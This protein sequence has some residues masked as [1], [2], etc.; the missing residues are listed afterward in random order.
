MAT[1]GKLRLR[2]GRVADWGQST[3]TRRL[4]LETC[5]IGCTCIVTKA[6]L[7]SPSQIMCL[8]LHCRKSL[9]STYQRGGG[10]GVCPR[11]ECQSVKA[12]RLEAISDGRVWKE[13]RVRPSD[14]I[15]L[16]LQANGLLQIF[17]VQFVNTLLYGKQTAYKGEKKKIKITHSPI[18]QR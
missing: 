16:F 14:G 5:C 17:I 12:S 6:R 4:P 7:S 8:G 10:P 2:V 18:T 9:L 1:L 13:N 3:L 15:H 11:W